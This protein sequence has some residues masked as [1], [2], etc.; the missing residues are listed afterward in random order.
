MILLGEYAH[1]ARYFKS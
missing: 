1:A